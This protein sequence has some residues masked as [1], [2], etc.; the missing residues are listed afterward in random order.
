MDLVAFITTET[1][2]DLIVSFAVCCRDDPTEIESLTLLRTP[3]YE[4]LLD[5][6]ERGA[7]VSFDRED[8]G[9]DERVLLREVRYAAAEKTV[10]V[11][12]DGGTYE[13]D[14]RKV[15]P[16]VEGHVPRPPNDELRFEH[17]TGRPVSGLI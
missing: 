2:T 3:K 11:R 10:T 15:D 9:D 7:S 14:V 5:E 4:S 13:L 16:E 1:G 12:S 8:G 17:Q 6:W